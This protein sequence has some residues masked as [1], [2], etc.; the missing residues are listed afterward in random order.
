MVRSFGDVSRVVRT[1]SRKNWGGNQRKS[2]SEDA[3]LKLFIINLGCVSY[4][5]VF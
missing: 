4:A 5:D 2:R 3:L 1:I